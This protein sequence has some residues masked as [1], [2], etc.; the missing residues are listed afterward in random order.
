MNIAFF[1]SKALS[2]LLATNL[3]GFFLMTEHCSIWLETIT[4]NIS[5]VDGA[6]VVILVNYNSISEGGYHEVTMEI[7][8]FV[9]RILGS[10]C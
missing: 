1:P 4:I 9:C 8:I 7:I 3:L 2:T 10:L 5:I 6:D